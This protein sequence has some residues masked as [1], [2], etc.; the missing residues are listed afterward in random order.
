MPTKLKMSVLLLFFDVT[1]Y[2]RRVGSGTCVLNYPSVRTPNMAAPTKGVYP[3][4]L[5]NQI[6]AVYV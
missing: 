5:F 4:L 2:G 6:I 1:K 3:R